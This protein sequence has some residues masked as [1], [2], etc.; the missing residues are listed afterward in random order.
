M[1]GYWEF[2][3]SGNPG[4]DASSNGADLEDFGIF[5]A[6]GSKGKGIETGFDSFLRDP[7]EKL[8]NTHGDFTWTA[9]IQSEDQ[10]N[11]ISNPDKE[12]APGNKNLFVRDG[13][14]GFDTSWIGDAG[15]G[16]GL[17]DNEWH[18]VAIVNQVV[19]G[20]T[21]QTFYVDGNPVAISGLPF[22]DQ[23]DLGLFSIG[24]G[25]DNFPEIGN[26]GDQDTPN[27]AGLTDEMRVY[28]QSLMLNAGGSV[29]PVSITAQP[30]DTTATTGRTA[31][32]RVEAA[33]TT[34]RYR[35]QKGRGDIPGANAA[36]LAI[37]NTSDAGEYR[38]VV[39]SNFSPDTVISD[40]SHTDDRSHPPTLPAG[41]SPCGAV[42]GKLLE[43]RRSSKRYGKR[44]I[45]QRTT[46]RRRSL[47]RRGYH[48][49][50]SRLWQFR[51]GS[52]HVS[53]RKYSH[54]SDGSGIV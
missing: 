16:P 12:W 45:T 14:L 46:T 28:T 24:Y 40:Q 53:A 49:G 54:I 1:A 18:H 43:L 22:G 35:W 6:D 2:E 21:E 25:S 11:I 20:E 37:S 10:G 3:T 48:V 51:R 44:P 33:G 26:L 17:I 15:S 41:N 38:V 42:P 31:R 9:M 7:D 50:Q 13:A 27:Y 52:R 47:E 32:L 19:D 39:S 8:D 36:K 30:E 4:E 34:V 23:L 5:A 29:I